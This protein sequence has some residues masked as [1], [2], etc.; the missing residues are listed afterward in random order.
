MKKL[1]AIGLVLA[2]CQVASAQLSADLEL[3]L[4]FDETEGRVAADASGNGRDGF[5]LNGREAG[6]DLRPAARQRRDGDCRQH[7][8][9]VL[10]TRRR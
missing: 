1:F 9:L 4:Q 2:A 5:I 6:G 8:D 10:G 3:Y 7:D